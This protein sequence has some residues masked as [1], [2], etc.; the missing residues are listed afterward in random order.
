MKAYNPEYPFEYTFMDAEFD[1][2]FKAEVLVQKLTGVFGVLAVLISCLGLFG[3]ASYTTQRRSKEI[4]IRKILGATINNITSMIASDFLKLI[5]LSF[6][7]AFPIAWF[8]M[9]NW[10]QTYEYRTPIYW[11]VFGGVGLLTL[12]CTLMT[13]GLQTLKAALRNP[14]EVLRSE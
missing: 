3:L 2:L 13:V 11:W 14:T 1:K 4:G 8:I 9:T 6:I 5:G 12:I 10:L 7:V